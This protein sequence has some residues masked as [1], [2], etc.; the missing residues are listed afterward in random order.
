ME[1]DPNWD[2]RYAQGWLYGTEPNDFV[3]ERAGDLR[4]GGAIL[5][6]AEGQGRNAVFLAGLGHVVTAVDR[7]TV[8]LEGARQL[9]AEKGVTI[10][11]VAADLAHWDPGVDRWDDI[12]STFAHLG[13]DSRAALHGRLV[14]ALR[15][16]G[17]LILEAYA[18]GQLV[19]G[20]G[21]PRDPDLLMSLRDLRAELR[22]LLFEHAVERQ[23]EVHEGDR[24]S[25]L[26]E[27]VQ[28]VARRPAS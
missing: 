8:A 6:V 27:V 12:V 9:A 11:V 24:H 19:C 10:E 1:P 17:I 20:T 22:G 25:G 3:R 28:V 16:G 13:P 15:P 7:S 26:A 21:G 5:C 2:S 23:R 14:E 4:P 18:K